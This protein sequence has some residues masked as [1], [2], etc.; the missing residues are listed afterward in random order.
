MRLAWKLSLALLPG[1]IAVLGASGYVRMQREISLFNE[2]TR[3][4]HRVLAQTLSEAVSVVWE[5]QGQP[6]ALALVRRADESRSGVRIRWVALDDDREGIAPAIAPGELKGLDSGDVSQKNLPEDPEQSWEENEERLVTYAPI[7]VEGR[8]EGAVEVMESLSSRSAYLKRTVRNT[9]LLT[10][11]LT[12]VCALATLAI[13]VRLITRPAR[14]LIAKARALGSDGATPPLDLRQKDEF[15]D[16]ARALDETERQLRQARE[17]A[18]E[19]SQARCQAL[20]QLRH[21]ERLATTGRLASAL[22]H[23][24]GT[25]L[26]VVSGHAQLVLQSGAD[27]ALVEDS[28]RII[29]GQ[30]DR[31]TKLVRQLLDYARRRPPSTSSTDL[32]DVAGVTVDLLRPLATRRQVEIEFDASDPG[33]AEVDAFQSQQAV[34]NI[35]MNAIQATPPNGKVRVAL[36]RTMTRAPDN[37]DAPELEYVVISVHDDGPGVPKLDRERVFEAFFTTK[38]GGDGTGLGLSIARDILREHGGWVA[39]ECVPGRG[40]RFDLCWPVSPLRVV[41]EQRSTPI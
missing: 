4:D 30:C 17:T 31:I 8:L 6:D 36:A 9:I 25:P 34:T 18:T 21:S 28:A 32:A 15:G 40:A 24:I 35:V 22:A 11:V 27:P 41:P 38:P 3:R 1:V 14:L 23:E 5:G 29:K 2:D 13:G 10:V 20:E 19:E 39:L 33:T 12:L 16:L 37:L 7:V 26:N